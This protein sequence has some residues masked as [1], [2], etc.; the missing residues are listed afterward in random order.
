MD[1]D[2]VMIGKRMIKTAL[3]LDESLSELL[4]VEVR[5]LKQLAKDKTTFEDIQRTNNLIRNVIIAITLTEEIIK[6][7]L[8]L[9]HGRYEN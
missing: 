9:Y 5:R 4:K 8:E 7:G 6:T 2:N 3:D 1:D